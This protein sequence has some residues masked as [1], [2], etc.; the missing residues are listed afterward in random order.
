MRIVNSLSVR[1]TKPE[2][3]MR[4]IKSVTVAAAVEE[5]KDKKTASTMNEYLS[6]ENPMVIPYLDSC[7]H[8]SGGFLSI[9]MRS[10][11]CTEI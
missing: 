9:L 1:R 5:V 2:D 8:L 6:K 7:T 4:N 10:R 3:K 11:E